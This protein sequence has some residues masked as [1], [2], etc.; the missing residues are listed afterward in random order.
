[1]ET[2]KINM[3]KWLDSELLDESVKKEIKAL[4]EKD[5]KDAFAIEMEFGTAGLRGVMGVGSNRMNVYNIKRAAYA[6]GQFLLEKYEDAKNMG[7]VIGHDN[8][9]NSKEFTM[10]TAGVLASLGIK[11][12]LYQN[13]E[14]R[15]TPLVS[16][17]CQR[18]KTCGGVV[19][20]A[21]H[22]PKEYNGFKVYDKN[23]CQ[24][25]D[26]VNIVYNNYMSI[27]DIFAIE[28]DEA[29][30]LIMYL[31][32]EIEE[33]YINDVLELSDSE[34]FKDVTITFTP[35]HGTSGNFV[36]P[37][38]EKAD[39]K[40]VPVT[41]QM[42][43]DPNFSNTEVPNPEDPKAFTLALKYAKESNSD[44][45]IST[46]PDGDRLGIMVLHNGEY[47]FMSGNETAAVLMDYW[48]NRLAK[49]LKM[50]NNAIMFN[51][52]VTSSLGEKVAKKYNIK[53]EQTLTGFKWI[54]TKIAEY[55]ESKSANAVFA[56]EESFGYMI[57]DSV[58][59]KDGVQASLLCAEA[60]AAAKIENKSLID[61][62]N[63]LREE[64]GYYYEK[65]VSIVHKGVEG[66]ELISRIMDHFT[67]ADIQAFGDFTVKSF[68][69]YNKGIDGIPSSNVLKYYFEDGSWVALRPSGTEPKIKF[70]YCVI[71]DSMENAEL[72]QKDIENAINGILKEVK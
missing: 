60:V 28:A 29:S 9:H 38:L 12:Y 39:F 17:S 36:V 8:R 63:D 61:K 51:T 20:T 31:D 66:K 43:E 25:T 46:D 56:Y 21:S 69:D 47:V 40:V 32:D 6:Y 65:N 48:F 5:A 22:N 23:G 53:H 68:K 16:Y 2:Y 70:Y 62:L 54:G 33:D 7:V 3:N 26:D 19:V 72:K 59:D 67:N 45:I 55:N 57:K 44:L 64:L 4:S 58:R 34:N 41:E 71:G 11:V 13:N 15:P 52:I 30:D 14:L 42:I 1:M 37:V 10:T 50:P 27:E 24:L 49:S 35:Q 18:L